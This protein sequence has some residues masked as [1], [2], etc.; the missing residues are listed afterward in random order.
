MLKSASN[1]A[2]KNAHAPGHAPM[3][4]TRPAATHPLASMHGAIGNQAVLRSLSS[5]PPS[6]Q[7]KLT[8]GEPGDRY[9]READHVASQVMRMPAPQIQRSCSCCSD[10]E[11]KED[12]L[13][14]SIQRKCSSCREE[15]EKLQKKAAP[16]SSPTG[17]GSEVSMPTLGAGSPLPAATRAFF[18]PRFGYN[19]GAVR[20]HNDATTQQFAH[21]IHARA[22][23]VGNNIAFAAG[24]YSREPDRHLL[25]HE[26][27]HVIQQD[28]GGMA[29]PVIRRAP[30][31]D[32]GCIAD[33]GA[34]LPSMEEFRDND[35]LRAIRAS[36]FA[37]QTLKLQQ[38]DKGPAVALV[39]RLLLNALCTGID[40]DALQMELSGETFGRATRRAVLTFQRTNVDALDHSLGHD[41]QVGILTLGAMDT[42]VG[43]A[44]QRPAQ[45]PEGR[46]DCYGVAKEGPG[47]A[48]ELTPKQVSILPSMFLG[49]PVWV[50]ENFDIAEHF[51]KTEHR[52]Y[53]R[54]VVVKLLNSKPPAQFPIHIIGEAS[55]TAN[56]EFD[57]KLSERRA[58]CVRQ[59]L[60]DA[61]LDSPTRIE[62]EIGIGK[63][64]G[65]AE[66]VAAGIGPDVGIETRSKRTVSIVVPSTGDCTAATRTHASNQFLARVACDSPTS[67]RVNIGD[68]SD[69]AN[70]TYREFVWEHAPWPQGCTFIP[71]AA[72]EPVR[73]DR[74]LQLASG[75]PDLPNGP[76]DFDGPA[77]HYSGSGS[78]L[79]SDL[80]L[81]NIDFVG[82]WTPDTCRSKSTRTSGTLFPI[83]PVKCG[84]VPAPPIGDC[85][86]KTKG[87]TDAHKMAA[88]QHF[89]GMLYGV[90]ADVATFLP[91]KWQRFLP[92]APTAAMVYFGTKGDGVDP[93]LSRAFVFAGGR[94]RGG[95]PL[96]R[97]NIASAPATDVGKPAQLA[98]EDP[99]GRFSDSDFVDWRPAR[100]WRYSTLTV[101]ANSN[102]IELD[103]DGLTTF[104]FFSRFCN[105]GE[106]R[107]Y[108]GIL[109]PAGSVECEGVKDWDFKEEN[110]KDEEK[111]PDKVRLAG[112]D[113]F[114]I[115][116]GRASLATLPAFGKRLAEK[117]GCSITAAFLNIQSDDASGDE[118]IN[119]EFILV[120]RNDSC[121]FTVAQGDVTL[122]F[123]VDRQ[124]AEGV[125]ITALSDFDGIAWL[126]DTGEL[127]IEPL[128]NLGVHFKLPGTFAASCTGKK[129]AKGA[130]LPKGKVQCGPA[131]TPEND[132]TPDR[133]HTDQ[134]NAF[135]AGNSSV[136]DEQILKLRASA[137]DSTLDAI[138]ARQEVAAPPEFYERWLSVWSQPG[139]GAHNPATVY[140]GVFV[141]WA[142]DPSNPAGEIDV[143][144][145]ADFRI[146]AIQ[147][148]G[149]MVIELRSDFCAF[150]TNGQVVT[151]IPDHCGDAIGR[152][153][154]IK[155]IRRLRMP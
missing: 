63:S 41:G 10:C 110:C 147:T 21:S 77:T 79:M 112:H 127:T 5:R 150:D 153:G 151:V 54:D 27:A 66:Q 48:R 145:F 91:A 109:Y 118:Q 14:K 142:N 139:P 59:A 75:D 9:E 62:E 25:A 31:P 92:V 20:V 90:S 28:R 78:Y 100:F 107:K 39:Q 135:R 23:T 124:V 103:I 34:P 32:A 29:A 80:M 134:C 97:L 125:D 26:L 82:D 111:C 105:H 154:D 46:G 45:D 81:F 56:V 40:R 117:Y 126:D 76:S 130:I 137:Y 95:E 84:M 132:T 88:A 55:T 155:S 72:F 89:N 30:D 65:V 7:T 60:I 120:A 47:E 43:L 106:E 93:P 69:P 13:Q 1:A 116:I 104:T 152:K 57:Q 6:I 94:L 119:R 129:G 50:L 15:D 70:L 67:V 61:G 16:G 86:P 122:N 36:T 101:L 131:P 74:D 64:R 38:G 4:V 144:G 37:R 53:L 140:R 8:I 71:E 58:H 73:P 3:R 52:A 24:E 99:G 121:P 51:V 17:G 115:R 138:T 143:V 108:Y 141:G 2:N 12:S 128:T 148:G 33:P 83:G 146:L 11:K 136:V 68:T 42:L 123:W 49:R 149:T 102:K 22:F 113:K 96:A 85:D 19:F 98:T 87:C 44:P 133:N 18:E 35:Q 114:T